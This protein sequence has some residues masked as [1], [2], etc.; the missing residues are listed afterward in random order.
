MRIVLAFIAVLIFGGCQV[1]PTK[2]VTQEPVMSE[3][4][5]AESLMKDKPVLLDVRP[6]FEFNLAHVPGAINV[7][8][9]DFSQSNPQSRGLLDND[10]F[11][12]ARRLSLVGIDPD[13]KVIVLGKGPQGT[14][15]E[16][17]VAWTLKVL[18]VKDVYT[19]LHTQY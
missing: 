10:L 16:G 17:R 3:G 2:V 8:W 11:S 7:R 13:T 5:F 4:Q 19:M 15:E 6:A 18:G 9:E 14:G 12:L 1:K